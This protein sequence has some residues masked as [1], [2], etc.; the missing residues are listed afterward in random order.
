MIEKVLQWANER[1][2]L[3]EENQTKQFIKL[4][5]EVGEL[6]N[7]ILKSNKAEQIDAIGDIQVVLI[8]LCKQLGL[9]YND[10]LSSAY[11]VIKNRTGKTVN[12][13]FIKD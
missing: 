5:E 12:G 8:I 6:A 10:C 3:Q 2:L 11:E 13:T 9:D 4:T 7:A 1:N